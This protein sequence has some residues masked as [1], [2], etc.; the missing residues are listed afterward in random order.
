MGKRG[1]KPQVRWWDRQGG[2]FFC[3]HNGRKVC[4]VLSQKDD[5]PNG[6]KYKAAVAAFAK[7]ICQEEGKGGD[8]F[9]VS[10]LFNA[11]RQVLADAGRTPMFN[12]VNTF[13]RPF[14]DLFGTLGVGEL[15]GYHV[16]E[17]LKA[18]PG[19]GPSSRRLA[20]NLLQGAFNWG[21]KERL[22][23]FNPL[24]GK[25]E[26]P[27]DKPRGRECRLSPEL[28][29]LLI[30]EAPP[31]FALY[32]RMLRG[33]GARP[34]EIAECTARDFRGDRI[35]YHWNA[36][37]GHK[38]K[39]ARRGKE[40]DRV[41]YL[42]PDLAELCR[43]QA[44]KHPR[45]HIFRTQKGSSWGPHN[46]ANAFDVLLKKEAVAA[47]LSAN[48][49]KS[50]HVVAYSFRHT[51]ISEW[52]DSGR[53]IKLCADLCGT[54]VLQIER[55]YGH[56]DEQNLQNVYLAFMNGEQHRPPA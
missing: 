47:Y 28:S 21:V 2:G 40:V 56:V 29:G 16:R 53:S 22:I 17:W 35:V 42:T 50:E 12:N 41:I 54:S 38:H 8:T 46:R 20:V 30:A 10:A 44:A 4:L 9:A 26:I 23:T 49:I 55:V 45:G 34:Q 24:K 18:K 14:S 36:T 43:A 39:T 11:Y 3:T 15:K 19:W 37:E 31:A 5:S 33:T 7:L 52:I 51:W 1:R 13:L 6:P 27:R 32:L 48:K 25:I